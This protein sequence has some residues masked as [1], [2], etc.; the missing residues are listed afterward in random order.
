M[1]LPPEKTPA[2]MPSP[3][4][5]TSTESLNAIDVFVDVIVKP[6]IRPLRPEERRMI[7]RFGRPE[8]PDNGR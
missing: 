7:E 3:Y 5:K 8:S 4:D 1:S 2:P 6:Q